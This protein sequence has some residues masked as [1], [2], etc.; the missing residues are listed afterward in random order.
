MQGEMKSR[1]QLLQELKKTHHR[2][3]ELEKS[4]IQHQKREEVLRKTNAL[5]KGLEDIINQTPVIVF[6][7]QAV[8]GWPV[9]F[10]TDNIGYFGYTPDDFYSGRV[11]YADIIHPDDLSRVAE[12]VASHSQE[13]GSESF[14]Q[15]YRI[16][17]NGRNVR[18]IEDR[19]SIKRDDNGNITHYQGIVLD[20]TERKEM[21]NALE[22]SEKEYRTIFEHTGTATVIIDEDTTLSLVNTEF[23]KLS[24]YSKEELEGGKSWADFVAEDD[25]ERM[26]EYHILRRTESSQ[27]PSNYE[28]KFIDKN[29]NIKNIFLTVTLI[30]GTK[31]SLASLLDITELKKVQ[32][33]ER[34]HSEEM[35]I[36]A[37]A[38][39][40]LVGLKTVDEIYNFITKK[41]EKLT[42]NSYIIISGYD[43]KSKLMTVKQIWGVDTHYLNEIAD[44]FGQDIYKIKFTLEEIN[45]EEFEPY[46]RRKLVKIPGGVNFLT[47][48]RA[49]KVLVKTIEKLMGIGDVYGMGFSW[50]GKQ[51]G[52]VTFL[53]KKG[54]ELKNKKLIETLINLTA[55]ALQRKFSEENLA[56]SEKRYRTIFEHT[57]TAMVIIDENTILSLVN[58]EFEKLSGY[59]KEE[60][61]GRK[62]WADFVAEDDLERMKEYHQLRRTNPDT[63]PKHYE[64]QF[65][66]KNKNIKDILLTVTVFPGT[67]KSL[68][69]LLNITDRKK[70]ELKVLESEERT[71]R[72][73]RKSFDAWVI[74]AGG[75]L[76]DSNPSA[77]EIM[78][79]KKSEDFLGK[80]L[81]DFVHP[82][83]KDAVS[84]R[85]LKMYTKGG[86][87]PLIEEKWLKLDGT[88]IDVETV[89]TS[90][91]YKGKPAVQ[92]AF[93][94]ITQRKKSEEAIKEQYIFLQR[95]IDTIPNPLFYKDVNYVY[96]GCNKP[97][98][99]FIG[100]SKDEIIGKTVYEIAP[101]DLA[102][103]YHKMDKELIERDQIQIYEAQVRYAD[104]SRH[105]VIFNKSTFNDSD[106]NVAGLIGVMVDITQHKM[107]EEQLKK[108]VKEKE[109][110]LKEIHHR[111]KNNLM[112]ISSLLNL[113]STFIKDKEALDIFRESQSR[114]K[115]MAL[116]HERLYQSV[117]LKRI[118]FG[119]Y[120]R[121]L[122]T[123]LFH[124][125]V[126]D[127]R[128]VKLNLDVDDLMLDINT[129][130]PLGLI[131]NELVS[132]CMKHAFPGA[133][134]GE[135]NIEFHKIDDEYVLKVYD[136]GVG[137]PEDLDFKN[138]ET[139]GLQ[140]INNLVGQVDGTIV[141]DR[142]HGTRFTIKFKELEL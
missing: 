10:V 127:P 41:I 65:M 79:G 34:L 138:T 44:V 93:R 126:A 125:Y 94:D 90:F 136:T 142:S 42:E 16:I 33:K 104:G 59:S 1:E 102:D 46:T 100:L 130:V 57:G 76:L 29:K 30:P 66:D 83:Y 20:I 39:I 82:D 98:E 12:E 47:E 134:K 71:R 7:W 120:I 106:G 96:L 40:T 8:E 22:E 110:L 27:A 15:E 135:I 107:A 19:T 113:Q 105:V 31:K 124:T 140:L 81:I 3:V 92:V 63:A 114:A 48:G 116:I 64:F 133:K 108:S 61:E 21:G 18:W 54:Y 58:T 49:P 38:T 115:S 132:N 69:S 23:E 75:N 67:K 129:T 17:T 112:V 60:L 131:V 74:H 70:A 26:K 50:E 53:V 4:E 78:G 139:L 91:E 103:E 97:F 56:D 86:T 36:I 118:N 101:K 55:I 122:S 119:D 137:F 89:A 6:I 35:E 121:T 72:L 37:D 11:P 13:G 68:A 25:L 141:L 2:M 52:G 28:F 84:K 80:P 85:T 14:K 109:T 43:N 73:L 32:E 95:L 117:D 111:V 123:D 5:Y 77:V 88:P 24:G 51:Y 45:S 99:E 62:S 87:V 9:D 128:A